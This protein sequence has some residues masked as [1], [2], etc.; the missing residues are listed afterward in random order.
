[1]PKSTISSSQDWIVGARDL[2]RED[3]KLVQ[4]YQLELLSKWQK[5]AFW[6]QQSAMLS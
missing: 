4:K 5:R 1:M 6:S 2:M 3:R